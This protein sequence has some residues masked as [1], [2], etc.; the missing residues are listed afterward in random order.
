QRLQ[1]GQAEGVVLVGLALG[2]LELPGL[3]GG[4]GDLAGQAQLG[5]QV[6]HPAGQGA[7]LEDDHAGAGPLEEPA[8]L[9]A[10]GIQGLE[11]VRGGG[12][13]EQAGDALVVAEV[14]S[15][16]GGGRR[17]RGSSVQG[18][19]GRSVHGKLRWGEGG[20]GI[21]IVSVYHAPR[22]TWILPANWGRDA[23]KTMPLKDAYRI[24]AGHGLERE[25]AAIRDMEIEWDLSYTSSVR[26]GF[27]VDLLTK[28]Q[29]LD[30]FTKQHWPAGDSPWGQRKKA[31]WLRLKS[32]DEDFLAGGD[33]SALQAEDEEE[34][35]AF[36]AE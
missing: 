3:A 36:A 15:E 2:V 1:L 21:V 13:V 23:M 4:V 5:A 18:G 22:L 29:L 28:K 10:G 6:V 26:R 27:V 34:D 25:M 31:F 19:R 35:Q 14:E 7:G 32:R 8:Q 11:A 12:A 24:G 30:A 9:V 17:G 33:E 20:L 16:N